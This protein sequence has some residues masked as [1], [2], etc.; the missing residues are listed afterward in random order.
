ML[1]DLNR[2]P[3]GKFTNFCRMS[4]ENFEHL[5][6]KIGPIINK[7]DT[8]MRKAIPIQD[9]LAVTLRFLIS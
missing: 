8:N 9:R 2:E 5:F 4:T 3:S 6:N 1:E 7:Q